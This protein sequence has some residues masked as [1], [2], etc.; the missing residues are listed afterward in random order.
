V[1]ESSELYKAIVKEADLLQKSLEG[2]VTVKV[3]DILVV[4]IC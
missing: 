2:I 1:D 4:I 3:C